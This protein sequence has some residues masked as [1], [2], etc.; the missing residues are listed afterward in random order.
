MPAAAER[1]KPSRPLIP[2]RDVSSAGRVTF[3]WLEYRT[4]CNR[5]EFKAAVHE[6]LL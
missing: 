3:W 6:R 5:L 4:G 2:A 1:P